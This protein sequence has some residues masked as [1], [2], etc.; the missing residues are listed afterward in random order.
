MCGTPA[1]N[2]HSIVYPIAYVCLQV[3]R[4]PPF[5]VDYPPQ[6]FNLTA[7]PDEMINLALLPAWR[8]QVEALDA[9]LRSVIDY[10]EIVI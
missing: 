6:L 3:G 10:E 9:V 4:Q 8:S 5:I 2:H 7:D 1:C